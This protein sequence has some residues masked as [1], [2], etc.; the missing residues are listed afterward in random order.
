VVSMVK[1]AWTVGSLIQGKMILKQV[2]KQVSKPDKSTLQSGHIKKI[3]VLQN[4]KRFEIQPVKGKLLDVALNQGKALQYKCRKGTCGLCTVKIVDAGS[5]LSAPN[6]KEQK[7]LNKALNDGCRL[8]C[9][10]EIC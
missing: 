7:K 3:I 4:E 8:A 5:G 6:E 9:Q 10:A 1:R 2:Q